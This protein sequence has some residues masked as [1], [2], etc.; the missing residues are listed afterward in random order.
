MARDVP[1]EEIRRLVD[2]FVRA[3]DA[4][5]R[6]E[7]LRNL[8][9]EAPPARKPRRARVAAPRSAPARA[10]TIEERIMD[11]IDAEPAVTSATIAKSLGIAVEEARTLVKQLVARGAIALVNH[12][13][14]PRIVRTSING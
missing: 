13:G 11:L 4:A 5:F 2:R 8:I 7:A 3:L 6:E 1:I 9:G 12:G 14:L 10:R